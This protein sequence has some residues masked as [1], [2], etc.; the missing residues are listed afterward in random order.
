MC[1]EEKGAGG[2]GGSGDRLPLREEIFDRSRV[3][4]G[5]GELYLDE[6]RKYKNKQYVFPLIILR[7]ERREG[8][9]HGIYISTLK[10]RKLDTEANGP[11]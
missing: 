8:G 7:G 11:E 10:Q 4:L 9:R 1:G 3:G 5:L 6:W 2:C